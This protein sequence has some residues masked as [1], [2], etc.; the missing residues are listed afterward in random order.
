MACECSPR[1]NRKPGGLASIYRYQF[2][3]SSAVM[4]VFS[5][6]ALQVLQEHHGA[7]SRDEAKEVNGFEPQ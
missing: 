7:W 5:T 2:T 6:S 3:P 1:E 4:V